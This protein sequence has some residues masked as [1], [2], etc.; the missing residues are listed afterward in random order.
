M[1][2]IVLCGGSLAGVSHAHGTH[3]DLMKLVDDQLAREPRNGELWYRRAELDLEHGDWAETLRD[4]EKTEECAPGK[5][6]V[7][8]VKGQVLDAENKPEEAK[9]VLDTFLSGNPTHWAAL[10]S[11]ARVETKLGLHEK[12]V[13][14]YTAALAN[15]REAEPD[16][17]QETAACLAANGHDDEAIRVLE[18][19]LKRLGAIPSLQI[20]VIEVEVNA[21]RYDAALARVAMIEKSAPRPEPWM[22]QRAGILIRAERPREARATW[23]SLLSHLQSLPDAERGS[24]AMSVFAR[25]AR[26]AIASLDSSTA[27]SN[28]FASPNP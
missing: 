19:G 25:Q 20:K 21:R 4:L 5:F 28:P 18:A 22:V 10:A 13:L 11:R 17:V 7:L 9:G 26:T 2:V 1:M 3:S 8:W 23:E 24:H 15:N 16:L 12:A 27:R 14:D 6:P